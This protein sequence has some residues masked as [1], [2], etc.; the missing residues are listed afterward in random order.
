[1]LAVAVVVGDMAVVA[2]R[3]G[4]AQQRA[5]QLPP[6]VTPPRLAQVVRLV[7]ILILLWAAMVLIHLSPQL[8]LMVVVV[9]APVT[10]LEV[11]AMAAPAVAPVIITTHL[12]LAAQQR[13]VKDMTVALTAEVLVTGAVAAAV[14]RVVLARMGICLVLEI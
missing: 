5:F 2:V 1:L 6:P 8:H 4:I 11:D 7:L 14:A 3:A 9:V 10:Q 13:L 12:V